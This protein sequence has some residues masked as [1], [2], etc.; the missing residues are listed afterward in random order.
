MKNKLLFILL[1][2]LLVSCSK[3]DKIYTLKYVIFYPQFSDTIILISDDEINW[4]SDQGTNYIYTYG[5][6][7]SYGY[8]GTAPFKILSYTVQTIK[9]DRT[10]K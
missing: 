3:S 1:I 8:N 7:N 2:I 5:N 10:N 9:N 6:G 4:H